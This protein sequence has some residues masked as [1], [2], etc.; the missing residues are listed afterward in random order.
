MEKS[1]AFV[2]TNYSNLKSEIAEGNGEYVAGLVESFGCSNVDAMSSRLQ[3]NYTT[4][5]APAKDAKELFYNIK[6]QIGSCIQ[7]CE[8]Y[9]LS[10]GLAHTDKKQFFIDPGTELPKGRKTDLKLFIGVL[11]Q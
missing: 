10:C 7:F 8:M 4:V 2:A 6:G 3:E 11:T 1:A 5:V 9:E